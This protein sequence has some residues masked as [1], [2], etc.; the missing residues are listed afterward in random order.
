MIY[1]KLRLDKFKIYD[2]FLRVFNA[3]LDSKY[4]EYADLILL[5][6]SAFF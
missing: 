2:E 3:V 6:Y 4:L 5:S 1:E